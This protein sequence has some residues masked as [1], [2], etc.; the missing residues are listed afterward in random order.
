MNAALTTLLTP[1]ERQSLN[2]LTLESRY[3]V[4]G[5]LA[6]R[7]R[8]AARG[9][10]TEFADHREY[11]PGD[12]PRRIDWKV[13]GRTER[14]YVRRYQDETNLRVY[15]VVDRS[16]SMKYGSARITKHQY[17]CRLAAAL[18]YVVV[19]GRDSVG[20]YAY[21]DRIE[22]AIGARNS[23]GHVNNLLTTLTSQPP[24]STTAT[25]EALRR[26][27][28]DIHRRALIVLISDLF[29]DPPG[30]IRALA[31]FRKLHHDVIL[32][33]L[34]DPME[35][36]LDFRHGGEFEDLETGEKI[37]ADPRRLMDAY[38]R[39]LGA[40]IEEYRSAAARMAIDYR[41]VRTNQ[42]L[43]GFARAYLEERRRLSR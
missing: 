40:F 1:A 35:L 8:S 25:A 22:A 28:D 27:A 9:S 7:H 2:R 37:V 43:D 30:I 10:S 11:N 19:K 6:G 13:L 5:N 33:H 34:L 12:D 26:V 21:S 32:F 42:P 24:A 20:L 38:R 4:E 15:L 29:D 23:F 16:A 18:S 41:L 14:Y 31:H 39:E 17:A 36:D 3:V